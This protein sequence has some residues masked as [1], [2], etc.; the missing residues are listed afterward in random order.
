MVNVH[1]IASHMHIRIEELK[2]LDADN[3]VDHDD[4]D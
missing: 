4:D 1:F 3:D 2:T